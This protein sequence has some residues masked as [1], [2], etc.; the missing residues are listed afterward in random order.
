MS[1][2]SLSCKLIEKK[3]KKAE[4][5]VDGQKIIVPAE[6]LPADVKDGEN[7]ELYFSNEKSAKMKEKELAQAI[8]EEILNGG[9]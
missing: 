7:L 3:G 8:L 4:V 1:I 6:N 5:E 2:N 9:K